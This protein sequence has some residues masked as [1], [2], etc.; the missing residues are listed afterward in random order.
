LWWRARGE[1]IA[2]VDLRRETLKQGVERSIGPSSQGKR[3]AEYR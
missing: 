2:I 1:S 3:W